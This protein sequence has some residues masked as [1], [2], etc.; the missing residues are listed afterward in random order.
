MIRVWDIEIKKENGSGSDDIVATERFFDRSIGEAW[1]VNHAG[2]G[3][4]IKGY[5]YPS[6]GDDESSDGDLYAD[7]ATADFILPATWTRTGAW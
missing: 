4:S 5:T 7:R 2:M 1:A 6:D 3:D